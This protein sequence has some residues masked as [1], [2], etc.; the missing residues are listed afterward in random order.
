MKE[1]EG[2]ALCEVSLCPERRLESEPGGP[3]EGPYPA[4][5]PLPPMGLVPRHGLSVGDAGLEGDRNVLSS[6]GAD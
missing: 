5:K 4:G 1:L 6:L 2:C 3:E